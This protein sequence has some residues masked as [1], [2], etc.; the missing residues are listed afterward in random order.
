[1]TLSFLFALLSCVN[2]STETT[3]PT[4]ISQAKTIPNNIPKVVVLGD[5]LSAGMGLSKNEAFPHILSEA[6]K[7]E[8][9]NTQIINAGVSGDTTAGGLRR[10]AWVLKQ[11][12]A[13]LI[14]E[15]GAND[16]MRGQPI[17]GIEHNLRT[18]IE[19]CQK[20]KVEVMLLGMRIPTNMGQEYTDSFA[21][22]YPKIAK[23]YN[24]SF[25]PFLLE[26]VAGKPEYN[27]ADGIHPN[28]EGQKILAQNVYDTLKTWRKKH[29]Q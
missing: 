3:T 20:E 7:D 14:L 13:L 5:S 23:E 28:K 2:T 25:V 9:L 24:I 6:L 1:M 19:T 29:A 4:E 11:K 22:I 21:A 16:G 26:K 18:I 15:L 10:L 17:D 27:Q 12:P 8:G